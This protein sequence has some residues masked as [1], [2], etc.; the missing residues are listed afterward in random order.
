MINIL[1]T[2]FSHVLTFSNVFSCICFYTGTP[3]NLNTTPDEH[4]LLELLADID[5]QWYVIGLVL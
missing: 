1:M 4:N 3:D 5:Y 2:S